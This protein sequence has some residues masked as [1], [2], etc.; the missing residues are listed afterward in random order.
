[1][2]YCRH[3]VVIKS[4]RIPCD[5]QVLAE[6]PISLIHS[7]DSSVKLPEDA[8]KLRKKTGIVPSAFSVTLLQYSSYLICS[9]WKTIVGMWSR[10][11][12]YKCNS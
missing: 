6:E 5:N 2:R 8:V 1:M 11:R 7:V 4:R 10:S 3:C 12:K 9:H